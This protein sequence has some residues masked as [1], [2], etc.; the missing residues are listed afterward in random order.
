MKGERGKWGALTRKGNREEER[1]ITLKGFERVIER[2]IIL[3]TYFPNA[4]AITRAHTVK[5]RCAAWGVGNDSSKSHR[6]PN[7]TPSAKHEKPAFELLVGK[8]QKFPK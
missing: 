8:S 2:C 6:L 1:Q 4:H 3:S 7:K 5:R